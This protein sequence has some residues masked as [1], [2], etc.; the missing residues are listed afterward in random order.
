MIIYL[1]RHGDCR[2]DTISRYLGQTNLPLN[3]K[4]RKQCRKWKDFFMRQPVE[5]IISSD[6]LRAEQ[7][8]KE[9]FGNTMEIIK[10]SSLREASLGD[11]DG[12]PIVEIKSK[13]P[14]EYELRGKNLA[15]YS[16]PN[17]ENFHDL[18]KRVISA[19]E[20]I[21]AENPGLEKILIVTHVGVIRVFL[22][23]IFDMP[24]QKI[25]TLGIDYCSLTIIEKTP[26]KSVVKG[27]NITPTFVS[28]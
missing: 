28:L 12:L 3:D 23:Y 14:E 22:A 10:C 8:T 27:V 25:F 4:G 21:C 24:L 1:L 17:G 5:K 15:D 20:H 26:H 6:L 7:T 13:F 11:W 9:I 2:L 18:Q 16:P 19:L